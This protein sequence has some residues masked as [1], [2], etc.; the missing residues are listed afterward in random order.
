[1]EDGTPRLKPS[2]ANVHISA[3]ATRSHIFLHIYAIFVFFKIT[4]FPVLCFSSMTEVDTCFRKEVLCH[5]TPD[6]L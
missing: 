5:Q 6:F 3:K 1:M 4:F 2:H